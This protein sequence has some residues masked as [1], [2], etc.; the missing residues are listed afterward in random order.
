MVCEWISNLKK[1]ELTHR[2]SRVQVK[3]H[4][5]SDK[6]QADK[7]G[8]D[9]LGYLVSLV[10]YHL[11]HDVHSGRA[12]D[13]NAFVVR[14]GWKIERFAFF[15][16]RTKFS[17]K[18]NNF[19]ETS[20]RMGKLQFFNFAENFYFSRPYKHLLSIF[21]RFDYNGMDFAR[22]L[23][24]PPIHSLPCFLRF[25]LIFCSIFGSSRLIPRF[26]APSS[27]SNA[28]VKPLVFALCKHY[29]RWGP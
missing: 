5:N 6:H 4:S 14:N 3:S 7:A 15:R 10:D 25:P 13:L 16:C 27:Y 11:D 23:Y 24:E 19:V 29:R 12:W 18:M 20:V 9:P 21:F 2:I 8:L 17:P 22:A 1:N 28:K 26:A